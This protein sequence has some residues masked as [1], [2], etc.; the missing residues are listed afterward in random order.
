METGSQ[1]TAKQ[2]IHAEHL[3]YCI[4]A[5]LGRNTLTR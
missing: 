5:L 3:Y 2:L 4:K 1:H